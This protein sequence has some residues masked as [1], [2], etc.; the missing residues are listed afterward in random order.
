MFREHG[1]QAFT[2]FANSLDEDH[3]AS[4]HTH[5]AFYELVS[6]AWN[7]RGIVGHV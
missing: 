7:L 3:V 4:S 2:R 5:A 6:A 1:A